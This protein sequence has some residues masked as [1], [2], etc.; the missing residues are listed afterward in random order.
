MNK[1]KNKK[2]FTLIELLVVIAII[3]LLSTLA[4]VALNSARQKSRDAKRVADIKQ[5]QTALEIY[6]NDNFEYPA[7]V[8]SGSSIGTT[9]GAG[10]I[11]M[12]GVPTA[13]T[14][15]DGTCEGDTGSNN[16]AYTYVQEDGPTG[17]SYSLSYCLGA[18]TGNVPAGPQTATP[19]GVY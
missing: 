14:P 6:Y 17:S 8:E 9:T 19:G 5:I 18:E 1:N 11:Y 16:N 13:P 3:G 10:V 12:T 15:A 4:I 2:G 7:N